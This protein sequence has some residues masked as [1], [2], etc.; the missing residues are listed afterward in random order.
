M[1]CYTMWLGIS[2]VLYTTVDY[3]IVLY[4]MVDYIIAQRLVGIRVLLHHG[5]E[6]CGATARWGS[7]SCQLLKSLKIVKIFKLQLSSVNLLVFRE[8]GKIKKVFI[9]VS[10]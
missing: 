4:T 10:I 8:N 9:S 3:S 5:G 2:V 7:V 1:W 6:Q